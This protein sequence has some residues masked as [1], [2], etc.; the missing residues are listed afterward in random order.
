[1]AA[2]VEWAHR[3]VPMAAF[4][5]GEPPDL[6]VCVVGDDGEAA[7]D[8]LRERSSRP[9]VR[10]LGRDV[11]YRIE[12]IVDVAVAAPDGER[13]AAW[14]ARRIGR[15]VEAISRPGPLALAARFAGRVGRSPER[16]HYA[17]GADGRVR[18]EA[19]ELHVVEHCNLRC[20]NCCNM[21]PLVGERT[22]SVD[23]VDALARRMASVLVA[24]VVKI[25]GG[26]P[27]LH[28]DLSGVLRALR[29][30]GVGRRV[31]LF[32]NGLR[33]H[34]MP[35]AFW[36]ALDELTISSYASA[37]VKPA[38]LAMARD[39]ARRHD[40][41]L[42]VKPVDEFSQ[43]LSPR[44]QPDPR[45]TFA[46]CWLRHRCLVVRDRRFYMCTRA[47]YAGD[48]LARV[49]HEPPAAPLDRSGDGIAIDAPDFAA[50]LEAYLNRT[51]PLAAC[52]YCFGGDGATEGHY[53]LTRDEVAAGVLSRKLVV[54]R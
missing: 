12:D 46:R 26:E 34:A 33:L 51:V 16:T 9:A 3:G 5:D 28:P 25:M 18:V 54:V 31:R 7:L 30:S 14:L 40:F 32:T 13:V 49:A 20:A 22:L 53:Q 50:D 44:Y 37:A 1:M 11:G 4:G 52:H 45:D 43:V 39:R 8:A 23:E 29:A 15:D 27:L 10:A 35:D 48:F 17:R 6:D 2:V 36:E 38:V 42:N 21:S 24:D 19:F 47:A 41:V